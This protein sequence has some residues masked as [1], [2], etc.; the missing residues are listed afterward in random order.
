MG[1]P[2]ISSAPPGRFH[3]LP[4]ISTGSAPSALRRTALHPWLHSAT[5][6]GSRN[7]TP[8]VSRADPGAFDSQRRARDLPAEKRSR[9]DA[10]GRVVRAGVDAA[11]FAVCQRRALVADDRLLGGLHL[12]AR[13]RGGL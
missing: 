12:S 5:P 1:N 4:S 6:P 8:E 11:R 9:V 7:E 2:R 13:T 10:L 3:F